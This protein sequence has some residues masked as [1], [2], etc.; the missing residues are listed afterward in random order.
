M[1]NGEPRRVGLIVNPLAGVGG[2]LGYKGSDGAYGIKAVMMGAELVSPSRAS[3]FLRALSRLLKRQGIKVELVLPPGLMGEASVREVLRESEV[4]E[5]RIEKCVSPKMWPT[6]AHDTIRCAKRMASSSEIIVFVGGDGT[7][8]NILYSIDQEVPSLGVPSGVKVYSSVFAV[9]PEK[10][11]EVLADYL[12]GRAV[13]EEREVVD[14]DE[15]EFRRGRLVLRVY[16]KMIVPVS[17]G[18]V[19]ASKSPDTKGDVE[20]IARYFAESIYRECTLYILG[21]GTTV[22]AIARAIGVG[23]KTL[24]GVD[25][26]HNGEIVARDADERRLLSLLNSYE[27]VAIVVSPIGGQGFIFGRGNQQISPEV[28]RRTGRDSILVVSSPEKLEELK[29][30]RVDTGDP[31]V[32]DML[33]GYMRVLIGYGRWRMVKV[34]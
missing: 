4:M 23:D 2:R 25:A 6:T 32:D 24:L 9:S 17:G 26:V 34:E 28:L 10:A 19:A 18:L 8:R 13:L 21:P 3:R 14:V 1:R 16:G 27:R 29:M 15:D 7:A 30:L 20:G 31:D 22:T 11:A 5:A 33:R 12:A